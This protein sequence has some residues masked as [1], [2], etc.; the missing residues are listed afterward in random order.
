[1]IDHRKVIPA[2]LH[3]LRLWKQFPIAAS[4]MVLVPHMLALPVLILQVKAP[5]LA[6]RYSPDIIPVILAVWA[7]ALMCIDIIVVSSATVMFVRSRVGA[8]GN[9]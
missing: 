6:V 5:H 4:G 8:R 9:V 2:L 3:S 1:M 7:V